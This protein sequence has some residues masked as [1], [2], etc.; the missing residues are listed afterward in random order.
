MPAV[1]GRESTIR[2]ADDSGVLMGISIDTVYANVEV[3]L[4]RQTYLSIYSSISLG[5]RGK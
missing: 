2:N 3:T 4:L 5:C 1:F